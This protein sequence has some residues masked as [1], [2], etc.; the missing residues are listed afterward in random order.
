LGATLSAG[1]VPK[2]LGA[3]YGS[4]ANIGFGVFATLRPAAPAGAAVVAAQGGHT[5]VM[6]ATDPAK[7]TCPVPV[8]ATTASRTTY[9]GTT[10]YFCSDS[11]RDVFL[12][13]PAMN[14]AMM[15]KP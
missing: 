2:E 12:K 6:T 3:V 14:V 10:Y 15:P 11:D 13:D 9:N 4:R 8:G 5:M 1:F 7:L